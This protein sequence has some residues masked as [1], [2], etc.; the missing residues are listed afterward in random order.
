MGNFGPA[1]VEREAIDNT[2]YQD[3][4][5][6]TQNLSF[7]LQ[8]RRAIM[9]RFNSYAEFHVVHIYRTVTTAAITSSIVSLSLS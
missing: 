6:L 9:N 8:Y 2:V 4:I 1:M 3:I 5:S 7:L